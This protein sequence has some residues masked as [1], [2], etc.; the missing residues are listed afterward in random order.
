MHSGR[1]PDESPQ[2]PTSAP[3]PAAGGDRGR[4]TA[5][6]AD[7]RPRAVKVLGVRALVRV[8]GGTE[9][10][11]NAI[12]GRQRA[13]V[14]RWQLVAAGTAADVIDRLI[15]RGRLYGIHRAVYGVAPE[16]EVPWGRETAALLALRPGAALAGRHALALWQ[17]TAHPGE[18]APVEVIVAGHHTG[19]R[20]GIRARHSGSLVAAD[21]TIHNGLPV[22]RVARALLDYA[23]DC[24]PRELELALDEALTTRRVS[25][26]KVREVI[27]RC[28]AGRVGAAALSRLVEER[29]PPG[30]TRSVAEERMRELLLAAGIP[31]PHMQVALFG[32]TADF[33]W[34]QA[35]YV[36]EF[37]GFDFH[38]TPMAVR[39]DH[40]KDRTL[41]AHGIRVDRFTW[42]D[43]TDG[44][45][46]TVGHIATTVA[47]RTAERRTAER[48][49]AEHRTAA[50]RT[51][52]RAATA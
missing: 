28:G 2:T 47:A 10:R 36:A 38:R 13:R 41:A 23:D 37:D 32:F 22:T 25:R 40:A 46:R 7:N 34:P 19:R 33:Y 39:R 8:E 12:A 49:T 4:S 29:R 43:I 6:S 52:G 31:V 21:I 48:R 14:A 11:L 44:A 45:L 5:N 42:E 24:T 51:P 35:A 15:A 20:A 9:E 3:T 16:I 27:A 18:G 26:T 1:G 30:V 17:V 50:R